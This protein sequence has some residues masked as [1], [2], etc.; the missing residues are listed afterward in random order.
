MTLLL[1]PILSPAAMVVQAYSLYRY[2]LLI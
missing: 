2:R 1:A